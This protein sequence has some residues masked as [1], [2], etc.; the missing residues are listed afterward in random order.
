[1]RRPKNYWRN[2]CDET[3]AAL[4]VARSDNKRMADQHEKWSIRVADSEAK[5]AK[6]AQVYKISLDQ[7]EATC[8]TLRQGIATVVKEKI[9]LQ[10]KIIELKAVNAALVEIIKP[11]GSHE[12]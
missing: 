11:K 2:L 1:V 5:M 12:D 9:E 8:Q 6:D 4:V 10:H 7:A 3:Q